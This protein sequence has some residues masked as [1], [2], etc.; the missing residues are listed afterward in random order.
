[1][2]ARL[3]MTDDQFAAW[4]ESVKPCRYCDTKFV[5]PVCPRCERPLINYP[6]AR[7]RP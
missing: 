6:S 1:V 5:G 4:V 2:R 7:R 3:G